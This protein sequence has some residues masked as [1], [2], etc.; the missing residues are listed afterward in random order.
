MPL[1]ARPS[2]KPKSCT[3]LERA[4]SSRSWRARSCRPAGAL[5]A[6]LGQERSQARLAPP[7]EVREAAYGQ[8]PLPFDHDLG[9]LV[10]KAFQFEVVRQ[11]L[12]RLER[13]APRAGG[14]PD[15]ADLDHENPGVQI[16][17][18]KPSD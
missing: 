3:T 15:G 6:L 12:M 2:V 1:A 7:L 10:G 14:K 9:E 4:A 5:D 8:G 11:H 16:A 13:R 17:E 18:G